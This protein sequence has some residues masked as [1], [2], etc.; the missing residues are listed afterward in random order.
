PMPASV[1]AGI[2]DVT[3]RE[4][5]AR[6]GRANLAL[7]HSPAHTFGA[8]DELHRDADEIGVRE[9]DA[10]ADVTVVVQDVDPSSPKL[11]VHAVGL[12]RN[13]RGLLTPARN[14]D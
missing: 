5:V 7:D 3:Q 6:T 1:H 13:G 10:R 9:L 2:G 8:H 14:G 4:L 11:L 12:R